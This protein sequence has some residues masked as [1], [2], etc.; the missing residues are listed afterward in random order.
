MEIIYDSDVMDSFVTD[1]NIFESILSMLQPPSSSLLSGEL[2]GSGINSINKCVQKSARKMKRIS[3][4]AQRQKEAMILSENSLIKEA[5]NIK[6]FN[7]YDLSDVSLKYIDNREEKIV[8]ESKKINN[9]DDTL[10]HELDDFNQTMEYTLNELNKANTKTQEYDNNYHIDDI[11]L[12]NINLKENTDTQ[13]YL[14]ESNVNHKALLEN[15]N[16]YGGTEEVM[17]KENFEDKN[18]DNTIILDDLYNDIDDDY[19]YDDFYYEDN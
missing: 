13:E 14:E 19:L 5:N 10:Q 8:E 17:L 12:N 16:K 6:I 18:S 4:S 11:S 1:A 3:I 15:I 9:V 7:D 2:L